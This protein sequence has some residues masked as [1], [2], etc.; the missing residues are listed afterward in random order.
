MINNNDLQGDFASL[1]KS[2]PN[3]VQFE[4]ANI[5]ER[6]KAALAGTD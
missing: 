6:K 4:F 2:L 1:G 3:G 5:G